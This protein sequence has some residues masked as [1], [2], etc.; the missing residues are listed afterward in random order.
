MDK[1]HPLAVNEGDTREVQGDA[2]TFSK[3]LI[4]RRT[5]FID[6]LARNLTFQQ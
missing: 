5:E 6:R 4:A 2:P 3:S 1:R